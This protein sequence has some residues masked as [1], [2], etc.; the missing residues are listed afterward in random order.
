MT[1][2]SQPNLP[3]LH[4]FRYCASSW[5]TYTFINYSVFLFFHI[6]K[7]I[8]KTIYPHIYVHTVYLVHSVQRTVVVGLRTVIK[9]KHLSHCLIYFHGLQVL[10]PPPFLQPHSCSGNY[11][12]CSI[13]SYVVPVC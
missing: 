4:R 2:P 12:H 6:R 7:I 5:Y 8:L 13:M 1:R 3:K 9:C 10:L 11:L